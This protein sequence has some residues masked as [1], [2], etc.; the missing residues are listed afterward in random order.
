MASFSARRVNH[1]LKSTLGLWAATV[2]A[3]QWM[4]PDGYDRR[5][6]T[7]AP[8][9]DVLW[10]VKMRI[11]VPTNEVLRLPSLFETADGSR[12]MPEAGPRLAWRTA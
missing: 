3:C 5:Y 2:A 12:V 4:T 10:L 11:V 6:E 8:A 9:R 7:D 1:D